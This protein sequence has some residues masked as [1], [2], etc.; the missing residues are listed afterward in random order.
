MNNKSVSKLIKKILLISAALILF[1]GLLEAVLRLGFIQPAFE[2]AGGKLIVL[3][4]RIL[5]KMKTHGK[6]D[7]NNMGFR[8][9]D[10]PE[11][12]KGGKRVLFMGDSFIFGDGGVAAG[13][14]IPAFLQEKLG[15]PFEVINM[16]VI[17]YGPDQ[18]LIS[19]IDQGFAL[20]PDMVI[21]GVC[22]NDFGDLYRNRL[23]KLSNGRTL[24]YSHPNV[25]ES[26]IPPLDILYFMEYLRYKY[27]IMTNDV[28]L[29]DLN[30]KYIYLF[31]MLFDDIADYDMLKNQRTETNVYKVDLMTAVLKE[32][33]RKLEVKK[34]PFLVIIIPGQETLTEGFRLKAAGILPSKQPTVAGIIESICQRSDIPYINLYPILLDQEVIREKMKEN[35]MY[36]FDKHFSSWGC[37][38]IAMIIAEFLRPQSLTDLTLHQ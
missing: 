14:T 30:A 32:F 29:H 13:E 9:K 4:R 37:K 6:Y 34:I 10:I 5:F 11:K 25:V 26:V 23:F 24:V 19:L 1:G 27:K 15:K 31:K 21:L 17:G 16:G 7:I 38:R 2:Q 22:E 3:D 20:R 33:Q 12:C 28:F 18:S 35:G 8:G 36:T